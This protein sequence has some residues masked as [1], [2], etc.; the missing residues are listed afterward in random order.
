MG[1]RFNS[2]NTDD[3]NNTDV[4]SR[5]RAL[6][7][8]TMDT[9]PTNSSSSLQTEQSLEEFPEGSSHES[10]HISP[11]YSGSSSQ[12]EHSLEDSP[13]GRRNTLTAN[14]SSSSQTDLHQPPDHIDEINDDTTHQNRTKA[15]RSKIAHL[16]NGVKGRKSEE[17]RT[18]NVTTSE[19]VND[20]T[21]VEDKGRKMQTD[22]SDLVDE[23]KLRSSSD[24]GKMM[25]PVT[26]K[27]NL[28]D[29][30]NESGDQE[31]VT[32]QSS[33]NAVQD[34]VDKPSFHNMKGKNTSKVIENTG[35]RSR[36]NYFEYFG[37]R[38]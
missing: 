30:E 10:M 3:D 8:V 32:S 35:S 9:S 14:S 23:V 2:A 36:Q 25:K 24:Q 19:E 38:R 11:K 15:I 31:I 5:P 27:D 22:I 4:A 21:K 13:E 20:D 28:G 29:G 7:N 6:S 16:L 26:K 33:L 17:S 37:G 34:H 18:L 12:N 1:L